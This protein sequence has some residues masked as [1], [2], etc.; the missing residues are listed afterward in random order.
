MLSFYGEGL[1]LAK[2]PKWRLPVSIFPTTVPNWKPSLPSAMP[3][4][5]LLASQEL[6]DDLYSAMTVLHG[7]TVVTSSGGLGLKILVAR[8]QRGPTHNYKAII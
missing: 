8:R 7:V 1:I 6:L 2:P 3:G 4:E 5:E